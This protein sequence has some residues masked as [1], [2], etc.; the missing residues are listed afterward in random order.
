MTMTPEKK[1]A[2]WKRLSTPA[3]WIAMFGAAKLVTD[4]F[5][6]KFDDT[7]INNAANGIAT[8]LAMIGI[9]WGYESVEE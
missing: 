5:G 7:Q 8:L 4:A 2:L 1:K 9:C 3:F 6:I